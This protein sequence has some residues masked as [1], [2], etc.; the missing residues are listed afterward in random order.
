MMFT[1]VVISAR[2][3]ED[4]ASFTVSEGINAFVLNARHDDVVCL[5]VCQQRRIYTTWALRKRL[6]GSLL[7]RYQ[8]FQIKTTGFISS[9][10]AM[11]NDRC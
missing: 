1:G 11:T 9:Q 5:E 2:E 7:H 6:S 8:V 3:V 10:V 4:G